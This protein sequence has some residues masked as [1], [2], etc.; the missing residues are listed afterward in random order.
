MSDDNPQWE[1]RIEAI[2]PGRRRLTFEIPNVPEE[3]GEWFL[4]NI[5]ALYNSGGDCEHYSCDDGCPSFSFCESAAALEG[6]GDCLI[7]EVRRRVATRN[8]ATRA[9]ELPSAT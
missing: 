5:V 2:S 4:K 1:F 9:A 7:R 6:I 8:C 3:H